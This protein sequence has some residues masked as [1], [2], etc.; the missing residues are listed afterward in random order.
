MIELETFVKSVRGLP[1]E[2][3]AKQALAGL[4]RDKEVKSLS[5]LLKSYDKIQATVSD[6][7]PS[8]K[9][10]KKLTSIRKSVEKLLAKA[11]SEPVKREA[12]QL[13]GLL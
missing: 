13:L 11:D 12:S 7:G 10:K 1:L 2:T 5:K 4:V 3:T 6:K 8:T 9:S